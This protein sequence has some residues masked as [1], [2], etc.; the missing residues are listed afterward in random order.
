MSSLEPRRRS[1]LTRSQKT[2]RVYQ[3]GLASVGLGVAGLVS[4]VA[5]SALLGIVLLVL[6]TV[7]GLQAKKLLSGG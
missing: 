6:A 4:I 3:L 7:A 1:N 2:D 5:F